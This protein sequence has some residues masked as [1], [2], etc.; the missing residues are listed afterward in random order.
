[1]LVTIPVPRGTGSMGGGKGEKEEYEEYEE[2]EEEEKERNNNWTDTLTR[3]G[4]SPRT[5]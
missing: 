3:H 1:M 2:E 5:N 4:S